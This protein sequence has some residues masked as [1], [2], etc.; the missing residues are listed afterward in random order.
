M[1]KRRE[2]VHSE[3]SNTVILTL[4]AFLGSA[5]GGRRIQRLRELW[6]GIQLL[7]GNPE[8]Q[9]AQGRIEGSYFMSDLGIS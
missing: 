6:G 5:G 4:H 7:Y 1:C 3:E 9:I 8:E 2:R